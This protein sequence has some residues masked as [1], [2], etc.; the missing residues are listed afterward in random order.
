M[1]VSGRLAELPAAV[2]A[3]DVVGRVHRRRRRQVRNLAAGRDV[4]LSLLGGPQHRDE[5]LA[6]LSPVGLLAGSLEKIIKL[7]LST[8]C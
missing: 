6:L 3:P 2:R 4:P 5:L 7:E 1:A 8:D